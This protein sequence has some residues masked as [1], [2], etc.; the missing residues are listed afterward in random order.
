MRDAVQET[1]RPQG[2]GR[3]LEQECTQ[4]HKGAMEQGACIQ[5][6]EGAM[7]QGCPQA[8]EGA[9]RQT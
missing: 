2:R 1:M 3:G 9:R 4:R 8:P 5:A 7:E 6:P